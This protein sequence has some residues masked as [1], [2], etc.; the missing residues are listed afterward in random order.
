[1]RD[2]GFIN[3]RVPTRTLVRAEERY[4]ELQAEHARATAEQGL[5]LSVLNFNDFLRAVIACGLVRLENSELLQHM[6]T[7]PV[8]PGRQPRVRVA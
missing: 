2:L 6:E 1:M 7:N 8:R 5:D 4:K 3:L